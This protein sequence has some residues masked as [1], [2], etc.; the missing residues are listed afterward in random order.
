MAA[1]FFKKLINTSILNSL[2]MHVPLGVLKR[3]RSFHEPNL[4]QIWTDPN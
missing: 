2:K 4:I 1:F 3:R